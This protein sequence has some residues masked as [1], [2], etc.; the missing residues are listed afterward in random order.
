MT[1]TTPITADVIA[2]TARRV[3]LADAIGTLAQRTATLATAEYAEHAAAMLDEGS[4]LC[5]AVGCRTPAHDAAVPHTGRTLDAHGWTVTAIRH[6]PE[7]WTADVA[8]HDEL[9]P[10]AARALAAAVADVAAELDAL[11]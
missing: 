4:E 11:N 3:A 1:F 8:I 5:A 9:T 6:D 7:D 10:D 2:A